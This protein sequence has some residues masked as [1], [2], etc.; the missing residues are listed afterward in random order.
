MD[1]IRLA[2]DQKRG[3]GLVAFEVTAARRRA[4]RRGSGTGSGKHANLKNPKNG[5]PLPWLAVFNPLTLLSRNLAGYRLWRCGVR[6]VHLDGR[7][8]AVMAHAVPLVP[9]LRFT[10]S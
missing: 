1:S 10:H 3:A 6:G 5:H 2:L 9:N 8:E 7:T 4:Q